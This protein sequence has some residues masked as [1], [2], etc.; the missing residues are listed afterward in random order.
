MN[1]MH[2]WPS[3]INDRLAQCR[4]MRIE[5]PAAVA[6]L[7]DPQDPNL[8]VVDGV[9][10]IQIVGFLRKRT[11]I[12]DRLFGAVSIGDIEAQ[13]RAAA[14]DKA[15]NATILL[16]DSPGGEQ[17]GMTDLADAI[18]EHRNVKTIVAYVSD[19]AASGGYYAASQT[20]R[21][22]VDRDAIIGSIGTFTVITD[23]SGAAAAEGIK[24]HVIKRGEFKGFE[25]DG[26]PISD[27]VL[28]HM[29]DVV[30]SMGD[31]FVADVARGRGARLPIA[32]VEALADGKV[33]VGKEAVALG[34]VDD[35]GTFNN[36]V[37]Q[38]RRQSVFGAKQVA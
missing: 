38:L 35:V 5:L 30:N 6:V 4:G 33:W 29:Q 34:L 16:I 8:Q 3:W 17:A 7:A 18:W 21:I 9:A 13:I 27:A 14:S 12:F 15:I 19:M 23:T 28:D 20:E 25:V 31:I 1:I 22:I 36:T 26:A 10:I 32:R 37:D 2:A 11:G 24:V